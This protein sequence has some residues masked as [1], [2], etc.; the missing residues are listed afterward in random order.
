MKFT[1]YDFDGTIYNGDSTMDFIKFLIKKDKKILLHLPKMLLYFIKYKMK[2]IKKETMKECFFEV[3]NRFKNIDELVNE[4][5][6]EHE[7]NIKSFFKEK[8]THK[9]DIISSASPYFLLEPIAKKYKIYDLFASPVNKKTGKYKGKN[10]HNVE[11]VRLLHKK[12]PKCI[13]TEMYSDD[14]ISDKPLLELAEKSYIVKKDKIISYEE[15]LKIKPNPIKRFWNWGWGIYHKNEEI[16]NYLI[17]GFLTTVIS[18]ISYYIC[19]RTFLDP[20]IAIELQIANVISW[21][22]SVI[23]AYF[24]NRIFVFKSKEKNMIKEATSF[25]GSRIITLLL[26]MLCMFIIVSICGLYDLIGK[27]VSQIV[28]IIGNYIISK[29]FVFKKKN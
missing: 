27:I 15:Y 26:D 23:F 22:I 24:T 28:V 1:V 25:V 2:F 4:F 7:N 3:F 14:A 18:I 20:E 17:V 21:I 6:E 8:K 13:V 10:C 16:W 12:Y 9:Q 5:W 19:V 11:K 29:L